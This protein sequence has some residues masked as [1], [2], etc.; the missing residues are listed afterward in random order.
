LLPEL[1]LALGLVLSAPI[2]L[3][4]ED[5]LMAAITYDRCL[6]CVFKYEGGYVNHPADPGGATNY[7]HHHRDAL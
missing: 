1:A 5:R 4:K 3:P 6:T 7:G 2:P